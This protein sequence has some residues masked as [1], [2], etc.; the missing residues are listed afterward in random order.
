MSKGAPGVLLEDMAFQGR[1]EKVDAVAAVTHG[2]FIRA[3]QG[4]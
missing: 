3:R 1:E 4:F 2:M